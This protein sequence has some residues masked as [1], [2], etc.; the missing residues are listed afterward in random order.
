MAD[1]KLWLQIFGKDTTAGA[2]ASVKRRALD[3]KKS[4]AS[5]F[6][7]G[8][9]QRGLAA[10]GVALGAGATMRFL[11]DANIQVEKLRA[12]LRTF[13]GGD[14]AMAK[15]IFAD[16]QDFASTTPFELQNVVQSFITFRQAG[17][18]PTKAMMKDFGNIAAAMGRDI[19]DIAGAVQGAATGEME[20]LKAFGVVARV[21]GDKLKV[22][23]GG[24]TKTIGRDA[25]SI[26]GYL[27]ALSQERF[28]DAMAEQMKTPAGAI[29]NLKDNLFKLATQVGE[30]GL[31]GALVDVVMW[32]GRLTDKFQQQPMALRKSVQGS[33]LALKALRDT[34][35]LL[36]RLVKNG[37]EVAFEGVAAAVIWVGLKATEAL[38]AVPVGLNKLIEAANK[39]PGIDIEFRMPT[40]E[41]TIAALQAGF[42][43]ASAATIGD[44]RDMGDAL[45]DFRRSA[46]DAGE[47]YRASMAAGAAA[48]RDAAGAMD[49]LAAATDALGEARARAMLDPK[50]PG[51]GTRETGRH[52][53]ELKPKARRGG[54]LQQMEKTETTGFFANLEGE[55]NLVA[56]G[57]TS[58]FDA[59]FA[60][61]REQGIT[62]GNVI[63]G[64]FRGAAQAGTSGLAQYAGMKVAENI[65]EAFQAKAR[66][67]AFASNPFLAAFA[68]GQ[69]AAAKM[70][71]A[72]AGKWALLGGAAGAAGAAIGGGGGRGGGATGT[73]GAFAGDR[74]TLAGSGGRAKIIINGGPMLDM[75]RRDVRDELANALRDLRGT[76]ELEIEFTGGSD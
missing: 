38:N 46:I 62:T 73:G 67:T 45:G 44:L 52:A 7:F 28:G 56:S 65:A 25:G 33:L 19:T 2:F 47:S 39:L 11:V 21:E 10:V 53:F 48:T 22:S 43:R 35:V 31:T 69:L 32:V 8:G 27:Q 5:A 49:Q 72:T 60:H 20:R 59:M 55:A 41:E 30:A 23:F 26:V 18:A 57:I 37:L 4:V 16:L 29:S 12:Q 42:D 34:I 75:R 24:V 64:I 36:V 61:L 50:G 63:S 15:G 58:T 70:H 68:P 3:L 17:I 54:I 74:D 13:T 40:F 76:R 71:L 66:A 6:S 1:R 14:A 51:L 9:I